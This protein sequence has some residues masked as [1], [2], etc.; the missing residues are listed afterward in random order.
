MRTAKTLIRLGGC[1]G[2][3]ESSLGAQPLCW[4]CHEAA[5]IRMTI[6]Q[7]GKF[8]GR[9]FLSNFIDPGCIVLNFNQT[10]FVCRQSLF[11]FVF[12]FF[13]FCKPPYFRVIFILRFCDLR[14][15]RG[16]LNSRCIIFSYVN[17]IYENISRE[18]WIRERS[19]SRILAKI[20]F[21]QL[22]VNLQLPARKPCPIFFRLLDE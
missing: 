14:H 15:F 1:P 19:N 2:W 21:S 9:V 17:F 18:C 20:K 5:Q 13:K 4:F 12:F 16:D 11:L 22:I 8:D 3:S 6:D 7:E 10:N